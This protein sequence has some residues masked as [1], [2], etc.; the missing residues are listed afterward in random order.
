MPNG[1]EEVLEVD[2]S[3]IPALDINEPDANVDF[4]GIPEFDINQPD[5]TGEVDALPSQRE[6][7]QF[8]SLLSTQLLD[9]NES[10]AA[11]ETTIPR[12]D[13]I[14][15]ESI[16]Q[17]EEAFRQINQQNV[18]FFNDFNAEKVDRVEVNQPIPDLIPVDEALQT[19]VGDL[20]FSED[21]KDSR[22]YAVEHIKKF[23]PERFEA[24]KKRSDDGKFREE[25]EINLV[26]E[27]IKLKAEALRLM[28]DEKERQIQ[29]EA[30]ELVGSEEFQQISELAGEQAETLEEQT[31]Q[32]EEVKDLGLSLSDETQAIANELSELEEQS[33]TFVQKE[34]PKTAAKILDSQIKQSVTDARYVIDPEFRVQANTVNLV[35]RSI[36]DI[37]RGLANIPGVDAVLTNV[38]DKFSEDNKEEFSEMI[39][40]WVQTF[41]DLVAPIPTRLKEGRGLFEDQAEVTVGDQKL[42]VIF[43]Q[44][45]VIDVRLKEGI[46]VS[47]ELAQKA[48][49]EFDTNPTEIKSTVDEGL[50]L[51][52]MVSSISEIALLIGGTRAVTRGLSA[53]GASQRTSKVAGL[54]TTNFVMMN[55]GFYREARSQGLNDVQSAIFSTASAV[56]AT[57]VMLLNPG[58]FIFGREAVTKFTKQYA[59]ILAKGVSTRQALKETFKAG[60]KEALNFNLFVGSLAAADNITKYVTNKMTGK[61]AF[62][63]NITANQVKED[64]IINSLTGFLIGTSQGLPSSQVSRLQKD[65]L[66]S[67]VI[68]KDVFIPRITEK[69]RDGEIDKDTGEQMIAKIEEISSRIGNIPQDITVRD[70]SEMATLMEERIRL[71]I[72]AQD[73]ELGEAFKQ[74][75]EARIEEIDVEMSKIINKEPV[76]PEKPAE[77]VKDGEI[78]LTKFTEATEERFGEVIE[79]DAEGKQIRRKD[80]TREEF[81]AE[82]VR[83]QEV[84]EVEPE[85][86]TEAKKA[87]EI[88]GIDT[89]IKAE[90]AKI[91]EQQKLEE[92]GIEVIATSE[93]RIK[94]LEAQKVEAEPIKEVKPE[95]ITRE[96]KDIDT[97]I[98]AKSKEEI[99]EI[100]DAE[101][102]DVLKE[103]K[104]SLEE[105][106]VDKDI[107]KLAESKTIDDISQIDRDLKEEK[108][109]SPQE[110]ADRINKAIDNIRKAKAIGAP[111]LPALQDIS[112]KV[113]TDIQNKV[114]T[115]K[116]FEG[117]KEQFKR[118][119]S[120]I[121]Q[122]ASKEIQSRLLG[123]VKKELA[124]SKSE[125]KK[126]S[127][128]VNAELKR[129][130]AKSSLKNP[131]SL[132]VQR[133]Q[134]TAEWFSENPGQPIPERIVRELEELDKTNLTLL[135]NRELKNTLD[136]IRLLKT[137]GK[138][139]NRLK[140]ARIQRERDVRITEFNEIITGKKEID[141]TKKVLPETQ[142]KLSKKFG[143]AAKK[144]AGAIL[145]V[146]LLLPITV[147][148]KL[149][150]TQAVKDFLDIR[151]LKNHLNANN[152]IDILEENAKGTPYQGKI[153]EFMR[154]TINKA[155]DTELFGN[156]SKIQRVQAKLTELNISST[157]REVV[158]IEGDKLERNTMIDIF[159]SS[160]DPAKLASMKDMKSG[161]KF[162]QEFID[163]VINELTPEEKA[164]GEWAIDF[165]E[166]LYNEFNEVFRQ[167]NFTDAPKNEGYSPMV[168]KADFINK[169]EG[170][171]LTQNNLNYAK[172]STFK[173]F[174][175]ERI[176]S[177]AA[178]ELDA[179]G[180]LT[181]YITR[182]EH[183]KAFE[184]PLQEIN[185]TVEGMK[186][187]I[188]ETHGD[189]HFDLLQQWVKDIA[190][191][192]R[193]KTGEVEKML[194]SLRLGFT[195]GVLGF[196][197]VTAIK[198][199]I[200]LASFLTEISEVDI[201]KGLK[202]YWASGKKKQWDEFM[203]TIGA[204]R[205]R[206]KRMERDIADVDKSR[207]D[208]D[209][210]F[211]VHKLGDKSLGIIRGMDRL[212]VRSGFVAAYL[213]KGGKLGEPINEQALSFATGIIERTQPRG[214]IK[215]LSAFQKGSELTKLLT[216]FMNQPNQYFN[217]QYANIRA[218]N[219]G[220]IGK[221]QLAR[222]LFYSWIVPAVAFEWISR[223]G[224]A[225]EEDIMN[226]VLTA[227]LRNVFFLSAIV[228]SMRTGFDFQ[229]SPIENIPKEMAE[230]AKNFQRG[231]VGKA[232]YNLAFL[233]ALAK[234]LPITQ[235]E[236]TVIGVNDV[237][238]GKTKDWRRL[239]WS[240]WALR[241][242]DN[243]AGI[244]QKGVGSST[245]QIE[246][247]KS[248]G[249]VL[250]TDE[251]IESQ[252]K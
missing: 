144:I 46:S 73:A 227:P 157:L 123:E 202:E 178:I 25:D 74:A 61:D 93:A 72:Q 199:T 69:I 166:E 145:S 29:G 122:A 161:N 119:E 249:K 78:K 182:T 232:L 125:A 217:I 177:K 140:L 85:K 213:A 243:A 151:F 96:D 13:K 37:F 208:L 252:T 92:P 143:T 183:Y 103:E 9:I 242:N 179:I 48:V 176:G 4:P 206:A 194:K 231:E 129:F 87:E 156:N 159:I 154:G 191:D 162:S 53:L 200:S 228:E 90:K 20:L 52:K 220:R 184:L 31:A 186:R 174:T 164:F 24:I 80:L 28:F 218:Y 215:D 185:A 170:V 5:A 142:E 62:D 236:R 104:A 189:H 233:T 171:N 118:I 155:R 237:L 84:K 163:K 15:P 27:G 89:E 234:G 102:R 106:E 158:E 42:D 57:A 210:I 47:E 71:K 40:N 230:E 105:T 12:I 76:E 55:D 212:T 94:E 82:E 60:T 187:A 168:K 109:N 198:Q 172:A 108:L 75:N 38:V 247:Q 1:E 235:L 120:E 21:I 134:K 30:D 238:S 88:K 214:D 153:L 70:K 98:E 49:N 35:I 68:E 59:D 6:T 43:E 100:E 33:D 132:K 99:A 226:A 116:D 169:D 137:Q 111:E 128:Q 149:I 193:Y 7:D 86:P 39:S 201:G 101:R 241:E 115:A 54:F 180:I 91:E 110:F 95:D 45:R 133:L 223:G 114:E 107:K 152:M 203:D 113:L 16:Q 173:P 139:F 146:P 222:T 112:D 240:D 229:A 221:K 130:K 44:D 127:P 204:L 160:K 190:S 244:S 207:K 58:K 147:P 2:A 97:K 181:D 245:I 124:I 67:A 10:F 81:E 32:R 225:D 251:F 50:L 196:N 36:T 246:E 135:S 131:E 216:M 188:K 26:N 8:N 167:V 219:Q 11:P 141:P 51:P 121:E 64:L 17:S 14:T 175:K 211:N 117:L 18:T 136:D 197:L 41:D 19:S 138:T 22:T 3:G 150:K 63:F 65:A 34:Y 248:K 56:T 79:T 165:Y 148:T 250:T 205:F 209:K 224:N 126:L 83:E 192:G 23:D 239:I 195:K 77:E 66:F